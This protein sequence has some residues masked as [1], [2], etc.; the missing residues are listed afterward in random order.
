MKAICL[1]IGLLLLGWT[2]VSLSGKKPLVDSPAGTAG[3]TAI[4]EPDRDAVQR[5]QAAVTAKDLN[6]FSAAFDAAAKRDPKATAGLIEGSGEFRETAMRC[7]AQAWAE[8]DPAGARDW[9]GSLTD[10]TDRSSALT[11]VCF[12]IVQTDPGQAL[13]IAKEDGLNDGNGTIRNLAQQWAER[14]FSAAREWAKA[15]SQGPERNEIFGK[16]AMARAASDPVE[17]AQL[18]VSEIPPGPSQEEA[19]MT[20][21][22]RWLGRDSKAAAEWVAGFPDSDLKERANREIAGFLSAGGGP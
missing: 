16:L 18:V 22:N 2:A 6:R 21:L 10:A 20:V 4:R 1:A 14:D 15:L 5:I 11:Y 19:A 13:R 9:A 8:R 7:V 12:Q 17:A 3:I